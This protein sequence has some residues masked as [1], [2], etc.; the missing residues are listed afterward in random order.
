[1]LSINSQLDV[2]LNQEVR[3]KTGMLPEGDSVIHHVD[4]EGYSLPSR[5]NPKQ[6]YQD[7][8]RDS[9]R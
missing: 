2:H 4:E 9:S 8:I 1:M 5:L 6:T 7:P 3:V